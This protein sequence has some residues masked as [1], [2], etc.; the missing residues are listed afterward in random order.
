[1][2]LHINKR[3]A[4]PVSL[5]KVLCPIVKEIGLEFDIL[6]EGL[7]KNWEDIVGE[8][9]SKATTPVNI[10]NGILTL[11]VSSPVWLT[12]AKFY[13]IA[14]IKNINVFSRRY[15]INIDDIIILNLYIKQIFIG[16]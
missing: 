15:N 4:N 2:E 8:T 11:S 5:D 12:Q 6:F 9:N 13:K 3:K 14:F 7:K 16:V 10:K 1:M